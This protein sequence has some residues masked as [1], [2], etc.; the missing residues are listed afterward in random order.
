M[1]FHHV[2]VFTT[3]PYGGNSLAVF[4]QAAGLSGTR[5]L[6]ITQELRHFE[7]IFLGRAEDD[8]AWTAR[9]FDQ[10]EEFDFA[11]HPVIGAACVLHALHGDGERET[12]TLRLKARTVRVVTTK[13]GPGTYAGVLDQG[14]AAFLGR[15]QIPDVASWFSLTAADLDPALPPEVV[16]TGLSYLIVPVRGEA[17]ARARIT[18][19]LDDRLA[20]VGAQFAY[21]LDASGLEGRSWNNDGLTEDVATG[22]AAGCVAAYLRRHDRLG[23]GEPATLRQGRFTG[24]PSEM[25]ITAHGGGEAITAEVGGGVALVGE[26]L[27]AALPDES[28]IEGERG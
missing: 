19:P 18:A 26:G 1:H 16:S 7:S 14:A 6:R 2:D 11:G 8:L 13:R 3:R 22:S 20:R 24:R 4:P 25:T 10:F 28:D 17:M 15:P 5:M 21:L 9:V 27:L 23:D 12:W